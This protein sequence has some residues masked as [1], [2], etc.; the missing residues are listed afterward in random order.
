M[1]DFVQQ[2][3]REWE[4][5]RVPDSVANEMAADLAADLEEAEAEGVSAEEVL[6][7]ST[8]DPR[9]FAASWA[10]ER[11]V[12]PSAPQRQRQERASRGPL[13]PAALAA[14]AVV[15]LVGAAW[16][17]LAPG[18]RSVARA[19]T[20][21]HPLAPPAPSG[22]FVLHGAPVAAEVLVWILLL[23][24]VTSAIIVSAWLW[25]RSHGSRPPTAPA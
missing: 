19:P 17:A 22:P 16:L 9:S 6:G 8:F 24:V 12:I 2:C 25:S 1:S 4:R 20:T 14:L 13:V 7:R 23:L 3:R 15:G 10:A 21:P 18:S 11:G 5:L